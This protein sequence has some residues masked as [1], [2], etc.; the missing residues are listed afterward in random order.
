MFTVYSNMAMDWD[1][2]IQGLFDPSFQYDS[3]TASLPPGIHETNIAT[4]H[5]AMDCN[6]AHLE[7]HLGSLRQDGFDTTSISP[8][9]DETTVGTGYTAMCGTDGKQ[10][11]PPVV[12]SADAIRNSMNTTEHALVV[13]AGGV[14]YTTTMSI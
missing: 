1:V 5:T 7:S 11:I 3:T 6:D 10:T 13:H 9:I 8:K 2:D 14:F 12:E 4:S